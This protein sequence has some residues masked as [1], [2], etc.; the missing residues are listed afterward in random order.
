MPPFVAVAE[1][2]M[3]PNGVS[4]VEIATLFTP[5]MP[6]WQRIADRGCGLRA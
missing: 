5:T 1:S 3:P 6:D 2:L 4:G